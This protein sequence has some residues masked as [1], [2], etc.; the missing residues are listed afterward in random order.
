MA[1]TRHPILFVLI[2]I[3]AISVSPFA[4]ITSA[5]VVEQ[6]SLA[7][8]ALYNSTNGLGWKNDSNWMEK[9]V[10]TWAGVTVAEYHIASLVPFS[11]PFEV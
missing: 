7:L 6:D 3:L 2:I 10:D 9:S 4:K 8:V 5:Q 11:A 1:K